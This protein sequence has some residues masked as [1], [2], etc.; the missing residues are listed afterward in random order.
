M[1][2]V[3]A[4]AFLGI[5]SASAPAAIP[6]PARNDRLSIPSSARFFNASSCCSLFLRFLLLICS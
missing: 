1:S 2:V 6:S 5:P 3:V 4:F